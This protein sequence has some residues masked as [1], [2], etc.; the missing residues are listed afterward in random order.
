[1]N[2]VGRKRERELLEY[3]EKTSKSELVCVYGRRRVGKTFLV[4]QV[5]APYFAFHVVG[6]K[7]APT[8]AQ[9]E[10]FGL[11]LSD[12]GDDDPTPPRSW[13][14]A[15]NR[16]YKVVTSPD[17]PRSPHGKAII[18]IDEFPW[19][20]KQR[21]DFLSAFSTFWNRRSAS[22]PP[23]LVIIC[24][25]ATSWILDNM[26]S[27]ADDL[28]ARVT[29]SIFLEPFT[30]AESEKY[31]DEQGFE[32]DRETIVETQMVFGGLPF[33]FSLMHPAQSMWENVD[34]LCLAPRAQLRRETMILLESTMRRSKIYVELFSL[35]S[36][37]KFGMRK[38][39]LQRAL[40]YSVAQFTTAVD[41]S[42]KCGYL[43]EYRN[44]SKP[45]HPK[46]VQLVDPFILFH[47]HFIEPGI[48]D[49]VR[50]WADFVADQGR[51][52]NWRGNAFEIVCT[53]HIRQLREA[54]GIGDV[55][56][57]EYPWSSE[58]REGGAQIDLVI[59]RA[60]RVTNLCE[61]KF[62][63]A[64]YALSAENERELVRK[65]ELFREETG[66]RDALKTVLVSLR[67]TSGVRDGAI[68]KKVGIDDL[69]R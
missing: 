29:E 2:L 50:R 36:Q 44:L 69:F 64:P 7:E 45:R 9:L 67:G 60:D 46:Y 18:F 40:G 17:A 65:R 15:F 42:V 16:L 33:F 14:E 61:M 49:P 53:Y 32:W 22:A 41:E 48:G 23:L 1:M 62:T 24:G 57:K 5:F 38:R 37:H 4:E 21:S 63:D 47:Y 13:R 68:A 27:S 8:K 26:L 59:E 12:R 28:A 3:C 30:L 52:F 10:E 11:E 51:Y 6:S 35:L 56:T 66:T 39:D 19:F 25:S 31:F 58:R 20:C 55:Q 43:R 34:R 54:I